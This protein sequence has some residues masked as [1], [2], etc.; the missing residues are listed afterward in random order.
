MKRIISVLL[1][2]AI[3]MTELNIQSIPAFAAQT[4]KDIGGMPSADD[5]LLNEEQIEEQELQDSHGEE[6]DASETEVK[7]V[8]TNSLNE[9]ESDN[10]IQILEQVSDEEENT[11]EIEVEDVET[12]VLNETESV[13]SP[14]NNNELSEGAEGLE[15]PD[16]IEEKED[17]SVQTAGNFTHIILFAELSNEREIIGEE[18]IQ[19]YL[20]IF[21]GDEE[22]QN[23][24]KPYFERISG[25]Q[26][27][28]DNIFPQYDGVEAVP[29]VLDG[30]DGDYLE[31][32]GIIRAAV[33]QLAENGKV[34]E[35]YD[36]DGD[37]LWDYLT[38]I[39]PGTGE[40]VWGNAGL[41]DIE[42]GRY[43]IV[44]ADTLLRNVLKSFGYPDIQIEGKETD[45]VIPLA[46]FRDVISGWMDIPEITEDQV[47]YTL[48]ETPDDNSQSQAVILR[49]PN[50][51]TEFFVVEYGY[52]LKPDAQSGDEPDIFVY[53]ICK[54]GE[55]KGGNI[56]W[57]AYVFEPSNIYGNAD[58]KAGLSD[59][60][61]VYADGSNSGITIDNLMSY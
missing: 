55:E 27:Q 37:G 40:Y 6:G 1:F 51:D 21:D 50:S 13:D 28:V 12:N 4:E 16:E 30:M 19:K 35:D 54:T 47:G 33:A 11:T 22:H 17:F 52:S 14:E 58:L 42:V 31:N 45:A 60:A 61:L 3:L 49:S 24:M 44:Y 25:G 9:T 8:D 18:D 43:Q 46:F 41:E 20:D 39:L 56:P 7:D 2:A 53:R 10:Q 48:Y 5:I 23:A 34:S 32:E 57:S 26:L 36:Q 59:G 29:Y 15:E 38:I